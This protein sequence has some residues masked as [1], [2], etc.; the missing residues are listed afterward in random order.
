MLVACVLAIVIVAAR[1]RIHFGYFDD[2]KAA[3]VLAE[4]RFVEQ[5]NAQHFG[6][7]FDGAT[8]GFKTGVSREQLVAMLKYGFDLYGPLMG[9][10]G[11]ATTCFPEQV[12]MVRWFKSSKGSDLTVKLIWHVPDGKHARLAWL[13][14]ETGHAAFDPEIVKAHACGSRP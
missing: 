14:L 9:D 10:E 13:N 3:A 12:R 4:S 5:Y 7:I 11:A 1:T 8:D 6:E 2:D